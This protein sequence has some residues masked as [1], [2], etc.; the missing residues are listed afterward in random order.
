MKI[1][2]LQRTTL[3]D[4]PGKVAATIFTVGCNLNCPFCHNPELV[5]CSADLIDESLFFEFLNERK[6][7]I[8]GVCITGGEPTLQPDLYEFIK[9]VKDQNFLVKLDTNG[10]KPEV[11]E[12]LIKDDL[13]DYIAMD[14]KAP[15]KKYN[16]VVDRE[17]DVEKIKR[18]FELIK[19][20]T[21]EH[22]FRSTV[23]PPLHPRSDIIEMAQQIKG[24]KKYFIQQF[25]PA[26]KLVDPKHSQTRP[27]TKKELDGIIEEIKDW[28]EL[29]ELR[30]V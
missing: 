23:L 1:G 16:Q 10:L 2:G 29:C 28:F 12:L 26:E 9:K 8:D 7:L 11:I 4:F 13:L 6:K 27:Y 14:I 3:L 22:E 15:W 20:S 19:E 25:M 30:G 18:S 5:N 21:V 17:I 24:A